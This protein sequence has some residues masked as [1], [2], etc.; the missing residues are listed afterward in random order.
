M[1]Y[2]FGD[3]I[4]KFTIVC[5]HFEFFFSLSRKVNFMYTM[6]FGKSI[7]E[8]VVRAWV[9]NIVARS[10]CD[11]LCLILKL[12]KMLHQSVFELYFSYFTVL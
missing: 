12:I 8:R 6:K 2:E 5:N 7:G 4:Y 11:I 10:K 1:I 3:W 9:T